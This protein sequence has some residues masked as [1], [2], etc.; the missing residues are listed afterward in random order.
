MPFQYETHDLAF[1]PERRGMFSLVR[2]GAELVAKDKPSH[3]RPMVSLP[4][5]AF[6]YASEARKGRNRGS[7]AL[8]FAPYRSGLLQTERASW[9]RPIQTPEDR[10]TQALTRIWWMNGTGTIEICRAPRIFQSTPS[11]CHSTLLTCTSCPSLDMFVLKSWGWNLGLGLRWRS[12]LETPNCDAI[13]F[14]ECPRAT[15]F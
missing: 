10:K 3:L 8:G 12:W 2:L 6:S 1:F 15:R 11:L 9:T 5:S 14:L 13:P 4:L 7:E